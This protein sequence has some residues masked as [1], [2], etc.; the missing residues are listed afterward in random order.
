MSMNRNSRPLQLHDKGFQVNEYR[1]LDRLQSRLADDAARFTKGWRPSRLFAVR[2]SGGSI[3]PDIGVLLQPGWRAFYRRR[4]AL[5]SY[6]SLT[7][8]AASS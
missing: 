8:A 7:R 6:D 1:K 2:V 4:F 5:R 3:R